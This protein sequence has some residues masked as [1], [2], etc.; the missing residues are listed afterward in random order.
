[1]TRFRKPACSPGLSLVAVLFGISDRP[2]IFQRRQPRA[3]GAP[4]RDRCVAALGMTMVIVAGGIDL[5][6][7]SVIALSTVVTALLLRESR[8]L[9]AAAAARLPRAQ[10]AGS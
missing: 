3:D 6:V 4:D 2:A 1:M 9:L 7:G 5:S 8:P 10:P